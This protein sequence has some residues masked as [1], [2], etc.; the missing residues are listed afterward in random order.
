[1]KIFTRTAPTIETMRVTEA[2]IVRTADQLIP[3]VWTT[4][5]ALTTS[6]ELI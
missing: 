4:I 1:L 2:E 5:A 3:V 6:E